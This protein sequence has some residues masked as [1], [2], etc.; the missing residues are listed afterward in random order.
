M[1]GM[2]NKDGEFSFAKPDEF[3]LGFLHVTSFLGY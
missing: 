1:L 2:Q 3:G